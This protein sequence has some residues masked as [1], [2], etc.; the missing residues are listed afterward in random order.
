MG[1]VAEPLADQ[2]D[3]EIRRG[4][5][6]DGIVVDVARDPPALVLL[7][8]DEAL[9][10]ELPSPV[11]AF[12]LLEALVEVARALADLLVERGCERA[13]GVVRW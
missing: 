11:G 6:L 4:D 10:Q 2:L 1:V 12:Q 3:A 13:E 9:E 5:D 7:R 8:R